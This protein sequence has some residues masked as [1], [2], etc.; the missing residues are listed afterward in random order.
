MNTLPNRND[1]IYK[2]IE[3]FKDY[4]YTNCIA[5]EMA[6]RNGTVKELIKKIYNL[7]L[8]EYCP[9]EEEYCKLDK[10]LE[11]DYLIDKGIRTHISN[12][13]DI[14][15]EKK[16]TAYYEY[17]E[18]VKYISIFQK[19]KIE[20][21]I[22]KESLE[23]LRKDGDFIFNSFYNNIEK[24]KLI[25]DKFTT[26][27]SKTHT[28]SKPL[29]TR[30]IANEEGGLKSEEVDEKAIIENRKL[31][32]FKRPRLTIPIKISIEVSLKINLILPRS[33]L[34]A[35]ISKIK[36]D[37]DKDNTIIKTPLELI[38][39]DIAKSDNKHTQVKS[40]AKK[41]ADWFYVYDCYKILK[42]DNPK[43][44]DDTI[45]NEID[46]TLISHYDSIDNCYYSTE[47]YRKT[48]M[49]NM[50]YLI[51]DLGYKELITGISNKG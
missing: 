3:S 12:T 2:E 4:E 50:K 30:L 28:N 45:F 14:Y 24:Y 13:F 15:T 40:N 43:K 1:D 49:K 39:E 27:E 42:K 47:T 33:E 5:Y 19:K 51:D 44:T 7:P 11:E 9:Y 31:F 35:Y 34:I 22:T 6:I 48:I 16:H 18:K 32:R 46:L 29:L 37:Y 26:E 38:G 10:L 8:Y 23:I 17:A 20:E 21:I 25:F 41:W 36:D